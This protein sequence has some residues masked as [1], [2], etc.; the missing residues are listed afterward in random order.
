MFQK[1]RLAFEKS[2]PAALNAGS[3]DS[4]FL[5]NQTVLK[6]ATLDYSGKRP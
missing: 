6:K 5:L 1:F 2:L 3:A 4:P